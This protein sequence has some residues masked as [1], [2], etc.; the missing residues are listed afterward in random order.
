MANRLLC[1]SFAGPTAEGAEG[2]TTVVVKGRFED[3]RLTGVE[4]IFVAQSR[5]GVRY[6]GRLAW[7]RDGYPFASV[8]DRMAR[9]RVI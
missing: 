8:G 9:T 2:S 6:G 4:D 3:D 1:F 7:D 5:G